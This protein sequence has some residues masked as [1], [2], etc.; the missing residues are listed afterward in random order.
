MEMLKE[1]IANSGWKSL[2]VGLPEKPCVCSTKEEEIPD[3]NESTY[4][5]KGKKKA[6]EVQGF[7]TAH[8]R[9]TYEILECNIHP[10]VF[11]WL[12]GR[13]A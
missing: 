10:I 5:D 2:K 3:I 11:D 7:N 8:D 13:V 4:R 9:P 6:N 1:H 12:R